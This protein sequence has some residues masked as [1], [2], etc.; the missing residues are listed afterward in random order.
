LLTFKRVTGFLTLAALGLLGNLDTALAQNLTATPSTVNFNV[1]TGGTAPSQNVNITLNGASVV[2]QSVSATTNGFGNWLLPSVGS[3]SVFVSVNATGLAAGTYSGS[4]TAVTSSGTINFPVN[5]TVAATPT[6]TVNPAALNFAHQLGTTAPLPQTIAVTSSGGA[7]N[8]TVTATALSCGTTWL[9]V[10]PTGQVTTP[11]QI[12]VNIQPANLTAGTCTGNIQIVSAGGGANATVTIP[13]SLLVSTNPIIAA[14]PA[15]LTFTAQVGGGAPPAQSLSLTSSGGPLSYTAASSVGSPPGGA[16]LQV[17]NQSGTTNGAISVSV[18]T[19]GLA[20]GTYIGTINITSASAGNG[21]LSIPVTLNITAGPAL[22]LSSPTLS[23]AYQ[24]GQAQPQSQTVT[25][26]STSGQVSFT[27][28]AQAQTGQWLSASPTTGTAPGNFVVSVNT[29]GLAPGSYNGTI[30]VTPSG[31]T[32]TPQTI[33]VT[34]VVSNTALLVL[35]PNAASFTASVGSGISTSQNVAVTSTDGSTLSFSVGLSSGA[36]WL[37]VNTSS[38]STPANLSISANPSGLAAGTY[39]GT[40]TITAASGT[41]ANSPQTLPVTLNV[42]S[43]NTLSVAP[44][45]LTF[46][47]LPNAPAPASQTVNVTSTGAGSGQQ[48]TFAATVSYNQG[49][50]WL[51]VTPLNSTTPT[52]LTVTANGAGL[53]AGTYTGQI[54][55]ASPGVAQQTINVTLTVGATGGLSFAG[56][57]AHL[58]SAGLWKTI[59]TLV[60][61]G[62][63]ASTARL[64]FFDDNGNPLALPLSFPQTSTVPQTPVTTLDRTL[65]PGATLIIESTGPDAQVTQVGS[66]QLLTTGN[67][68]GFAVFRQTVPSGQHEAVVPIESRN[69]GSFILPFDN[70]SGFVTGVAMANVSTQAAPNIGVTIRDDNGVVIQSNTVALAALGHSSFDLT[71][72]FPVTAQRRGTIEFQ[73]PAGGQISVLGIRF[74]PAST[75]STVP[76]IAK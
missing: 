70:T 64:S 18:N 22:Q 9:I 45:A 7:T 59:F 8:A 27:V 40:V 48:I 68:T 42:T 17:P 11:T 33:Q 53:A 29:T 39:T 23:F 26:G 34:L 62:T 47:Q 10:S 60:N 36:S 3:S 49:Q 25:V 76:P 19:G 71:I 69:P 66:A 24:V 52:T 14:N 57:M 38:G 61:S 21:N 20:V 44:A 51:T 16:W 35:S 15:S 55:L 43:S 1:Q 67:I 12:A 46:S 72:R 4:V 5:L 54:T 37:L 58:A 50:G 30:T 13:V 74:N 31:A 73:T 28:A 75:F 63:V 41:V 6:V 32:N 2:I 56:S 65:G